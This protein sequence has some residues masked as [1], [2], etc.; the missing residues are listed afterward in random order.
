MVFEGEV[1]GP[2]GVVGRSHRLEHRE[3][4]QAMAVT[5]GR[6]RQDRVSWIEIAPTRRAQGATAHRYRSDHR[7]QL[8]NMVVLE[9]ISPTNR[10][11]RVPV[12]QFGFLAR[13]AQVEM[14]LQQ[15]PQDFAASPLPRDPRAD[16]GRSSRSRDLRGR[17]PRFRMIFSTHQRGQQ[18]RP[19]R[20]VSPGS[21]SMTARSC[22]YFPSAATSSGTTDKSELPP[23][24]FM[25]QR[26]HVA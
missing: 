1:V 26:Y 25:T 5:T 3:S 8:S 7:R 20:S 17:R 24:P 10:P 22:A 2:V 6:Q 23:L 9:A 14:V 19:C 15:L 11:G 4:A 12:G 13:R 16:G 18:W 21:S